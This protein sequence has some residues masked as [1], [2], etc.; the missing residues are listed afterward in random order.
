MDAKV[1]NF[2]DEEC[3]CWKI[4]LIDETLLSFEATVVK[5]MPICLMDQPDELIWPHNATSAYTVKS[6]YSPTLICSNHC[7]K[8]YGIVRYQ[9]K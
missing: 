6:G 3:R 2:I 4:E 5:N 9:A 8:G 7:C 1:Q